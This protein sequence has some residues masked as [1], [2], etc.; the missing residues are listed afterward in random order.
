MTSPG[1][2]PTAPVRRRPAGPQG[3]QLFSTEALR[4]YASDAGTA[5]DG[6]P[7]VQEPV[8]E[9]VGGPL[10]GRRFVL[11][12]GRQ[13]IGRR[14]NNDLVIDEPSVSSSHAW[15]INQRGHYVLM[16]TLSTNGTFVN[17]KR[18]HEVILRH[19]DHVRLGQAEFVFLTRERGAVA[20]SHL[21]WIAGG[22]GVLILA[23]VCAWWLVG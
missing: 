23:G 19:G 12:S 4:Q 3:T 13:T 20:A 21:R 9:A 7:S 14:E 2:T 1:P 16:N 22:L 11:R 6:R 10:A 18:I 5:S 17:D 8:L 15:I